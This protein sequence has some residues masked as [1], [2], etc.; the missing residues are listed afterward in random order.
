MDTPKPP[1]KRWRLVIHA[2]DP[3]S[4]RNFGSERKAYDALNAYATADESTEVGGKVD[5]RH[6][7]RGQW[8]LWESA[9]ITENGWESAP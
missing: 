6:W 2:T 3:A 8:V 5:I 9:V 1:S 7:E 4:V